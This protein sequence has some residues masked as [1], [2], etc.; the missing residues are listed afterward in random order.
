MLS[1]QLPAGKYGRAPNTR[2]NAARAS[3]RRV[4]AKKRHGDAGSPILGIKSRFPGVSRAAISDLRVPHFT[5]LAWLLATLIRSQPVEAG[6]PVL[7]PGG[8]VTRRLHLFHAGRFRRRRVSVKAAFAKTSRGS[9]ASGSVDILPSVEVRPNTGGCHSDLTRRTKQHEIDAREAANQ[10][11]DDVLTRLCGGFS[12]ARDRGLLSQSRSTLRLMSDILAWV[13]F[14]LQ[15][16]RATW[17]LP[18]R[19]VVERR[20]QAEESEINLRFYRSRWSTTSVRTT[21]R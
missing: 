13:S 15:V 6:G 7:V 11:Q 21:R 9:N 4:D 8:R 20:E 18:A 12:I 14:V 16:Y 1:A 3:G 2:A 17:P 19:S 5:D 10:Q